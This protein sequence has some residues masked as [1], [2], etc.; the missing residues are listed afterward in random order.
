MKSS[1]NGVFLANNLLQR[2]DFDISQKY[3][4]RFVIFGSL[5]LDMVKYI[6]SV[7]RNPFLLLLIMGSSFE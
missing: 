5:L 6:I 3:G 1:E 4:R 2:S 7:I